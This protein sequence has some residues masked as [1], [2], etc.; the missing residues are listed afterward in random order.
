MHILLLYTLSLK[1]EL[2]CHLVFKIFT[3]A[4]SIILRKRVFNF[5]I[6]L[7]GIGQCDDK[8]NFSVSVSKTFAYCHT[9]QHLKVVSKMETL[10]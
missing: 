4:T 10:S 3:Y 2:V 7:S 8:A 5:G 1:L 6:A 9:V